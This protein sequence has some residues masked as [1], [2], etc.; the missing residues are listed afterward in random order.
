[1]TPK[2]HFHKKSRR[3]TPNENRGISSLPLDDSLLLDTPIHLM[4][5]SKNLALVTDPD[6]PPG[7]L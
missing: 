7:Y 4:E 2:T 3:H 5:G 6:K 1:M